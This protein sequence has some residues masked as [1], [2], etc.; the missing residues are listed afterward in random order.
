MGKEANPGSTQAKAKGCVCPE[1]ENNRGRG[2]DGKG[3]HFY[4]DPQC[5]VHGVIIRRER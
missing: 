4:I 2:V 3:E 5:P 1:K